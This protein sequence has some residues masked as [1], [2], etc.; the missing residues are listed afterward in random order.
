MKQFLPA[1][2]LSWLELLFFVLVFLRVRTTEYVVK[3]RAGGHAITALDQRLSE[4]MR[5]VYLDINT[6]KRKHSHQQIHAS[7][8]RS[9]SSS[10]G[11][12]SVPEHH[13]SANHTSLEPSLIIGH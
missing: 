7:P 13:R 2:D 3:S 10:A 4:R 6:A 9:R 11:S 8:L 1:T 5:F 12:M